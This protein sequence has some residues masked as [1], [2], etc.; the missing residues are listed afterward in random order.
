MEVQ[1]LTDAFGLAVTDIDLSAPL[2]DHDETSLRQ[3]FA[4]RSLLLFREQT[5][6]HDDQRHFVTT[7]GPV[8]TALLPPATDSETQTGFYLSNES[9]DGQGELQPHSDHCFLDQPLWGIS[10][11]AQAAP[12][13]G[14]QTTFTSAVAACRNLPT[15]LER[16]LAGRDAVHSYVARERLGDDLRDPNLPDTLSAQHP[17]IWEHPVTGAPVLYVNPWMT[18]QIVGVSPDESQTLLAVLLSYLAD[19]SISYRHTW[20]RGDFIVWDNIALLHARTT[21]DPRQARLLYRLQLGLP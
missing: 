4:A 5:L 15:D 3:L 13:H 10:L 19:P 14:G 1:P 11:Y 21:Y 7:L 20:H 6:S 17:V 16:S 8:S 12:E 2:S 18:R 9:G